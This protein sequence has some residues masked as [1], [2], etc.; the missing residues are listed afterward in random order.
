MEDLSAEWALA[1]DSDSSRKAVRRRPMFLQHK[2]PTWRF[3]ELSSQSAGYA[4]DAVAV[5]GRP[6]PDDRRAA[7]TYERQTP[8]GRSRW[9]CERLRNGNSE[10]IGLLLF[11]AALN[12]VCIRRRPLA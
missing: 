1:S 3:D 7:L 8:L 11:G 4:R 2:E 10:T 5:G 12:D 6:D 9:W